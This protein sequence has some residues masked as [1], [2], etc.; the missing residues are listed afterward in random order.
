MFAQNAAA[1]QTSTFTWSGSGTNSNWVWQTGSNWVGNAAPTTGTSGNFVFNNNVGTTNRNNIGNLTATNMSFV[2]GAGAFTLSGSAINLGSI[3]NTSANTQ[4]LSLGV[5]QSTSGTYNASAN[6]TLSGSLSGAGNILKTG[7]STLALNGSKASYT[8]TVTVSSGTL[9]FGSSMS[10][11]NVNMQDNTTLANTSGGDL[12]LKNLEISG[13]NVS[14]PSSNLGFLFSGGG[15]TNSTGSQLTISNNV[16]FSKNSTINAGANGMTLTGVVAGSGTTTSIGTGLLDMTNSSN[17]HT[18]L[19]VIQSGTTRLSSG[20]GADFIVKSGAVLESTTGGNGTVA[21]VTMENG[22]I[23]LPG[24]PD[25]IG[26]IS[27][28]TDITLAASSI[29]GFDV[30]GSDPAASGSPGID[31][32]Q[33]KFAAGGDTGVLN[34]NGFVDLN[35]TTST[36]FDNGVSFLLFNNSDTGTYASNL[37]GFNTTTTTGA[38]PYSGLTFT[39]FAGTNQSDKD[40][41]GLV[42]GDW[43]SSWNGDGHQRLIFSQS[44]GTLTVVPEPSTIVF[45][46]IGMAMFGWSTWT[47]RRANARRQAIEAAIA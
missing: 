35:F 17:G 42:T 39:D 12:T 46:G 10:S 38:S 13:S 23:L 28:N 6:I 4:T 25:S 32:D 7:A 8:G 44:T 43:I 36:T 5:I 20:F 3:A 26:R 24:G 2:N 47:R 29:V 1:V 15:L 27:A 41:F 22:G 14:L 30:G 11:G 16:T 9:S 18:G 40:Y 45:A 21:K 31:F 33:V 19:F 34:Y 37:V